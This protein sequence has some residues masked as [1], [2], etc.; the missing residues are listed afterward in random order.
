MLKFCNSFR[1][2]YRW[3][4][5]GSFAHVFLDAKVAQSF[6]EWGTRLQKSNPTVTH[7]HQH[8]YTSSLIVVLSLL[9]TWLWA[10]NTQQV[11]KWASSSLIAQNSSTPAWISDRSE[12]PV[13][14]FCLL[15]WESWLMTWQSSSMQIANICHSTSSTPYIYLLILL[16]ISAYYWLFVRGGQWCMF[17]HDAVQKKAISCNPH[18]Q[19]SF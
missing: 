18:I 10:V 19:C 6:G 4:L 13:H 9:N 7:T 3:C 17:L 14:L 15:G 2:V 1:F 8:T 16:N 5:F 11:F 12:A